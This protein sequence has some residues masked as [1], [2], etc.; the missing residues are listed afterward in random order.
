MVRANNGRLNGLPDHPAP[1]RPNAVAAARTIVFTAFEPSGD[2]HA[3]HVIRELRLRHPDPGT[4]RL[5][6]WGGPK[7]AAAGAEVLE[8]TVDEAVMGIPG[9]ARIREHLKV[10]ERIDA[11][12]GTEVA[13]GRRNL[14]HVPV[15]S[16]GANGSI[17]D[18]S[19]KHGL[20]VVHLVAPQVWAWGR[21]RVNT[22]RR[23]TD[24]LLCLF[25]FEIRFFSRRRIPARY[26]GHPFFDVPLDTSGLDARAAEYPRGTPRVAVFPG[27]RPAELRKHFP[28]TLGAFRE[29]KKKWGG[30]VGVVAATNE[31]AERVMRELAVEEGGPWPE[32]LRIVVG[33]S[34]AAIRWCDLALVKSGTT[35]LQVARQH[36][37]MVVFYRKGGRI[38]NAIVRLVVATKRFSLPNILAG[39]PIVPEL[40]PYHGGPR[41]LVEAAAALL[42]SPEA[43]EQQR[44]DLAQVVAPLAAGGASARA[45]DAIEEVLGLRP[46]SSA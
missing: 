23:R 11:W 31:Q 25:D 41:R 39:R 5:V 36:K 9:I 27:S 34:E 7:M 38:F 42:R 10:L 13:A 18:A 22:L 14:L 28:I 43:M 20:R 17:C 8:R 2:E 40:I 46:A 4:L 24:L 37:P 15:D 30:L 6:A 19:R 16:P 21:W 1:P 45:A 26:I 3:S 29:L 35:T 44:R 32:D 12:M 33:Q